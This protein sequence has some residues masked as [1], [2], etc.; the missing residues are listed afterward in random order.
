MTGTT[1]DFMFAIMSLAMGMMCHF[2]NITIIITKVY[3]LKTVNFSISSIYKIC[4]N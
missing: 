4:E 3:L 2:V 1:T